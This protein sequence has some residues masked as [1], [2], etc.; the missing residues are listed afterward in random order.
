MAG[1]DK[2]YCYSY[3]EYKEFKDWADKQVITFFDGLKKC[4]GKYVYYY[5]EEDFAN[6]S[7]RVIMKSPKWIDI[8]LVQNCKFEFILDQ[9]EEAY[10]DSYEKF[11]TIDLSAKPSIE[12]QQNRKMTIQKDNSILYPRCNKFRGY[13][14]QKWRLCSGHRNKYWY[15]TESKRWVD[16]FDYPFDENDVY[17]PSMKSVVRHLRK[18]YLKKGAVFVIWDILSGEGYNIIIK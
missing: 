12:Y 13:K 15:N 6:C 14:K 17:L 8:Y 11:K 9:L 3:K 18:Q 10:L 16:K 5:D 1:I 2:T 7:Q 4:V